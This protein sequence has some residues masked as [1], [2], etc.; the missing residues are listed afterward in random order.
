MSRHGHPAPGPL[1]PRAHTPVFWL[2]FGAGGMLSA[3]IGATLVLIT[4]LLIPLGWPVGWLDYGRVLAFAQHGLVRLALLGVTALFAWH[5]AH[6]LLCCVHDLGIHKTL[7]VKL[8]G[9]GCAAL[10]TGV[11]ALALRGLPPA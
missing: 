7:T 5:A 8:I 4:G 1:S 6:R 10:V 2:L 9:Y 3:L 11:A